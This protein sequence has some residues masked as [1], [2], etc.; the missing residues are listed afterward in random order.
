MVSRFMQEPHELHWKAAKWIL[1]YIKGTHSYG[2]HYAA[3][4]DIDLVGHIDLDWA[5]DCQ[6]RKSTFGYCFSLGSSPVCWSSK[7]Q[8]AIAFS[9][10]KAEYRGEINA[11][12]EAIWIQNILTEFGIPF[13]KPIVIFCDNRSAIQIS[14]NPVH[15]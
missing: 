4:V 6:D 5:G 9:S 14:R 2:I 12:T 10:T 1:H 13:R 7:K 3:G 8:F 15:H 11:T